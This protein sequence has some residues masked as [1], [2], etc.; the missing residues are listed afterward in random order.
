M[1]TVTTHFC[2]NC[3]GPL[4]FNPENQNFN[5]EY[6]LSIFTLKDIEEMAEK[7]DPARTTTEQ[8]Q[9]TE[10]DL[11]SCGSCGAEIVTEPTTAAT[12]CYFCHNPVV[13][14]ERV[15]GKFLPSKILPFKIDSKK[16]T[17]DFFAW[18]KKK[19]FIPKEFFSKENVEKMTGVY[20]PYWVVDAEVQGEFQAEGVSVATWREGNTEYTKKSYY[21]VY[22]QGQANLEDLVKNAL[23]KNE[24]Q[25]MVASVQPF[26]IEEAVDFHSQYLTGFQ[27]EKRDIEIQDLQADIEKELEWYTVQLIKSTAHYDYFNE[28]SHSVNIEKQNNQYMLLPVWVITY[29]DKGSGKDY[30]YAMNGQ[31]GKTEGVLPIDNRRLTF[32]ALKVFVILLLVF[33]FFGSLT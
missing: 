30:F 28:N 19:R 15:S 32:F 31:T 18:T 16:A 11:F 21:Q 26:S 10:L 5:C 25:K 6:C 3:A 12:Y 14:S 7:S 4:L 1:S 29:H 33:L 20:F 24:H 13:L 8:K 17:D 9:K 22:R 27:A 2:L 23:S